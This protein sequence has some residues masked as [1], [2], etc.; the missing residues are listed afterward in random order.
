M[1]ETVDRQ[2]SFIYEPIEA[3]LERVVQNLR[4]LAAQSGQLRDDALLEHAVLSGGKKLRPAITL[5]ASRF[6]PHQGDAV[7]V[8]ATAVELLHIATLIHDDT[9]DRA[10]L[11]RGRATVSSHWGQDVAVMLGDYVFAISATFVC[12]TENVRVIR[13]FSE[14]IM[15]LARGQLTERFS[16]HDWKQTIQDYN[17]RIYNKTASL[18]CTAAG[19]GAVLSG[20]PEPQCESLRN[21]GYNLGMAFQIMDDVLDFQ[22]TEH[23]LGKPVGNDLLQGTLTLPALLFARRYP[24]DAVLRRL[25]EGSRDAADLK[26]MVDQVRSSPAM[27]ETLAVM[28]RYQDAARTSL[29]V[30]PAGRAR[31]SLAALTD[32]VIDRRT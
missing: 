21:Y 18:F 20:A 25:R 12:D 3:D 19:S 24:D 31:E 17:E 13:R 10:S 4:D 11:R 28:R 9:V 22:G 30:L 1:T 8:M 7:V 2:V 15:E 23:E 6:H 27:D 32:Y 29:N 14:T 26:S 16:V 5:L